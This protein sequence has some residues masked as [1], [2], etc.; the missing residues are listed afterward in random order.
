MR[1]SRALSSARV[2]RESSSWPRRTSSG[3]TWGAITSSGCFWQSGLGWTLLLLVSPLTQW[4]QKLSPVLTEHD[5]VT[6]VSLWTLLEEFPGLCGLL[7]LQIWCI[8]SLWP[9]YLAV[10]VAVFGCCLWCSIGFPGD[11]WDAMLGSPAD[12]LRRVWVL[13]VSKLDSCGDAMGAILGS[14]VDTCSASAS[15][16]SLTNFT[17]FPRCGGL[18]FCSIVSVLMQNGEVGPADA[19]LH[20]LFRAAHKKKSGH[21]FCDDP[22]L[23]VGVMILGIVAAFLHHFSG[24]SSE[25]SPRVSQQALALV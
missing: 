5:I 23:A 17:Y 9:S 13:L 7:A 19:P 10:I 1:R 20:G 15:R 6:P 11:A 21:Y 25:L 18:V 4:S 12:G 24:S 16:G 22:W 8:I 3:T 14:T 2:L